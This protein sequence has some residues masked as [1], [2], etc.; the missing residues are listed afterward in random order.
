MLFAFPQGFCCNPK[1]LSRLLLIVYV[2]TTANVAF[3]S[4]V[5][6]VTRH[7][8]IQNPAI[9]STVMAQAVFHFKW[10]AGRIGL[11]G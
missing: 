11:V 3:E 8:M 1:I 5:G 6:C 7:A 9:F 4:S 2:K 10:L